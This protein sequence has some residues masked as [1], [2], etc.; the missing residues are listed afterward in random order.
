MVQ[1]LSPIT[2]LVDFVETHDHLHSILVS[3][4][5]G[6]WGVKNL[7]VVHELEPCSFPVRLT[8][9]ERI[10]LSLGVSVEEELYLNR[11]L[12]WRTTQW[13][14]S[15]DVIPKKSVIYLIGHKLVTFLHLKLEM[16]HVRMEG[17]D[18][19]ICRTFQVFR[20]ELYD[21]LLLAEPI[22]KHSNI[23]GL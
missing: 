1:N 12:T 9:E 13:E 20:C 11:D 16:N 23:T 21:S 3:E 6:S 4:H 17:F 7:V 19:F 15:A 2:E 5:H 10:F 14:W 8:A 22:N 18:N